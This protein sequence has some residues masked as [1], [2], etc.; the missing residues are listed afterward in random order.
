MDVDEPPPVSTFHRR[1]AKAR[2]EQRLRSEARTVQKLLAGFQL[3]STH[4][5]SQPTR[6]GRALQSTLARDQQPPQFVPE[7][8]H[9]AAGR[10]SYGQACKFSHSMP[11]QAFN[12]N[13]PEFQPAAAPPVLPAVLA[14]GTADQAADT[15]P[16]CWSAQSPPTWK[17]Q[18]DSQS[19]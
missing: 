16:S 10:C 11:T 8:R 12:P 6:L 19:R 1:P 4:R 14:A 18:N 7:C 5:G 2:R 3:L 17:S 13:A 9:F 15:T